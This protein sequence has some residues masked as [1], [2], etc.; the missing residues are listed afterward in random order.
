MKCLIKVLEPIWVFL[1]KVN[2]WSF[3]L[4]AS[5]GHQH[6]YYTMQCT[7]AGGVLQDKDKIQ[8]AT[9][10]YMANFTL[11]AATH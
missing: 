6:N 5:S 11:L 8:T 10:C 3:V 4:Q 7:C 9:L 1:F 2:L